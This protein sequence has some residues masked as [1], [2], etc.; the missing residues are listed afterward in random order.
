LERKGGFYFE[1]FGSIFRRGG[2]ER[3]GE[4]ILLHSKNYP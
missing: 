2:D 4:Q 3:E 1:V